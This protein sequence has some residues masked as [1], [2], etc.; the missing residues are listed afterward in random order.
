MLAI[1]STSGT[2]AKKITKNMMMIMVIII[3]TPIKVP[4]LVSSVRR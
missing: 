1:V 2:M 4:T 3:I